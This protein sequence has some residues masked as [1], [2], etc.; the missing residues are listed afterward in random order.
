M[1]LPKYMG[2]IINHYKDP[3]NAFNTTAYFL[4][5]NSC[6]HQSLGSHGCRTKVCAVARSI[7]ALQKCSKRS[8]ERQLKIYQYWCLRLHHEGFSK[9]GSM[10]VVYWDLGR[11][12][13]KKAG[14]RRSPYKVIKFGHGK[15]VMGFTGCSNVVIYCN[16]SKCLTALL[17]TSNPCHFE[18]WNIL[19]FVG[20]N[21]GNEILLSS[22]AGW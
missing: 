10:A 6:R 2:I 15:G 22:I 1:I 3:K 17:S 21:I 9:G 18:Q 5:T 8:R 20:R 16:A 11:C 19:V 12:E 4:I 7:T 14:P 13:T